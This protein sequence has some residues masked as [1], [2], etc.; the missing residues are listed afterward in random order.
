MEALVL[1]KTNAFLN[2]INDE[3]DIDENL[4]IC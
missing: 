3:P 2:L 1:G 4:F